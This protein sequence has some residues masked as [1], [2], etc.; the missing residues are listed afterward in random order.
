MGILIG[1]A[2]P[3]NSASASNMCVS[4]GTALRA[5]D[6]CPVLSRVL[7]EGTELELRCRPSAKFGRSVE[8]CKTSCVPVPL[9]VGR[10]T[11]TPNRSSKTS[12]LSV[13]LSMIFSYR[14][15]IGMPEVMIPL[16]HSYTV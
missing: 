16:A 7:T 9:L 11:S 12:F 6:R 13:C 4:L 3:L 14:L 15:N 2:I 1:T 8:S 5:L 10:S